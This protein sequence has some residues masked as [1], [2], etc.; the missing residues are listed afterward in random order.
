MDVK[1]LLIKNLKVNIIIDLAEEMKIYQKPEKKSLEQIFETLKIL[2]E[3]ENKTPCVGNIIEKIVPSQLIETN[4]IEE[5]K[6]QPPP[7]HTSKFKQ[8]MMKK[9]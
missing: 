7:A 1:K 2:E 3:E 6:T 4:I 5:I 8:E 9:K